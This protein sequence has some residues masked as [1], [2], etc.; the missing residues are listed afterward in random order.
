VINSNLGLISHHF[1]DMAIYSWKHSIKNCAQ[2]A[3]DG[4]MVII[5]SL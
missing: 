4:G 5:D 2:T 3:A 1:Q